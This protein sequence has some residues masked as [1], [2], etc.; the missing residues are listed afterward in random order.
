[1]GANRESFDLT[2]KYGRRAFWG[3]IINGRPRFCL[4]RIPWKTAFEDTF[5]QF[6]C[7]VVDH[8][9]YDCSDNQDESEWACTRCHRYIIIKK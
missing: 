9:P 8:I 3:K 1:M 4:S 5:T 2:T 7:K 6:I